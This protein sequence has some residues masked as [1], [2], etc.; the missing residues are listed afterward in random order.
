VTRGIRPK[1]PSSSRGFAREARGVQGVRGVRGV[2]GVHGVLGV[3]GLKT[4]NGKLNFYFFSCPRGCSPASMRTAEGREGEGGGEGR[5]GRER[6]GEGD[7]SARTPMFARTWASARSHPSV[8]AD[9]P[10]FTSGNFKKDATVRPSH[11][12]PRGHR[13]IVRPSENVRVTTMVGTGQP[14]A[15]R[16]LTPRK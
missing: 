3:P 6:G 15:N 2:Q 13:P 8:H 11:R 9:A 5:G 14:C 1:K 12:C 10:C 16:K 4:E 7:A